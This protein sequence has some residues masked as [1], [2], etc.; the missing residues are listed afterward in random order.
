MLRSIDK[1][2]SGTVPKVLQG[3]VATDIVQDL[4][5]SIHPYGAFVIPK[6]A[7]AVGVFHTIPHLVYV[8]DDPRLGVYRETFGGQLMM[9]EQRP[10]DDMTDHPEYGNSD[11]VISAQKLYQEINDD[12]DHRVDQHAF[13]R[14]RLFD[15]FLSDWDRHR[16]QWRWASF[17]SE[18]GEG[19]IYRPIPRDRDWAFNRMNG[20]IPKLAALVMPKFQE[21]SDSYGFLQGLTENG[22]E[23]DRRLTNALSRDEWVKAALEIEEALT[24]EVIG[25]AIA[26]WPEAVRQHHG[27]EVIR[28]L[29]VRRNKLPHVAEEVYELYA[30]VVDIVGSNKHERFEV[31][32]H[33][34]GQTDVVV[35]KTN[36][37]GEIRK[38]IY[39][40]MFFPDETR[41]IRLYGL[42][43][44]DRINVT[45][46]G[47]DGILVTAV[48]G[49]GDDTF[50]D[51]S[52]VASLRKRIRFYDST[53]GNST[54][55][56]GEA[57]IVLA[58]DPLV[59]KYDSHMY[60]HDDT[61]P[62]T[63][64]GS[65]QDDGIF[66]GGGVTFVRHGFRKVPYGT[67]QTVKANFAA[68]TQA[69]NLAYH[70]H[71][72]S[73]FNQWNL[74]L[75]TDYRS[76]TNIRNY[77][78]LGNETENEPVHAAYY[79]ANL[80]GFNFRSL[81]ER[82]LEE[83]VTLSFGPTVEITQVEEDATKYIVVPQAGVSENTFADQW[84]A[85]VNV[86]L[87]M[88]SLDD[89]VNP[90]QGFRW[91]TTADAKLGIRNAIDHYGQIQSD[92]SIFFSPSL[93]PQVTL[94]IRLGGAHNIGDF[95]FY[96]ANTLGGRA[97]L[98]GF[99]GTR[100][101]GRSSIYQNIDLRFKLLNVSTYVA[102][103]ELGVLGFFD[104]GRVW[105]DDESSRQW[106]QGYG[107]G[108]WLNLF[109]Q[110]VLTGTMDSSSE[111][112]TFTLSFGFMY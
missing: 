112:R 96:D 76:P 74:I 104:N 14:A 63:F 105:T 57:K 8:P 42:D 61:V 83:G 38:E 98:R 40:R 90:R 55:S 50:V 29:K 37:D 17:E 35:C 78:G 7:D 111:E 97:N 66:L 64:F 67:S 36:K 3:T 59:N 80:T 13:M 32:R 34:G 85:G 23:Q 69:F 65:N 53:S 60:Q 84:F 41:E 86:G 94:A 73:V 21:F 71:F 110:F 82:D 91:N 18:D 4:I 51:D 72:V 88:Q 31:T 19:K 52:Q 43:G 12:N 99:R 58:D 1:D 56:D 47:N 106:H 24:D 92:L 49:L 25:L 79:Q 44:R 10:D 27:D 108:L 75:E 20:L 101:A 28:I 6:M 22:L 46:S 95:P 9:F 81:I 87:E 11:K 16:D 62:T 102:I 15:M 68:R 5:S 93:S 54:E 48:G 77:Y 39:R 107:G 26:D 103:G 109:D 70:G 45:G 33:E 100:Y 2:P 89:N 30:R